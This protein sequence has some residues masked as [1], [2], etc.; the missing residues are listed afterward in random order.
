MEQT[1]IKPKTNNPEDFILK[2]ILNNQI[3]NRAYFFTPNY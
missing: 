3:I 1:P 2:L